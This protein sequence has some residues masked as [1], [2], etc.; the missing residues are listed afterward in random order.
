MD[1]VGRHDS[2]APV[3]TGPIE[4]HHGMGIG[5]DWR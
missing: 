3:P 4:D 2:P 1:I 5:G